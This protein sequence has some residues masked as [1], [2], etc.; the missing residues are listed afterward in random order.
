MG[1]FAVFFFFGVGVWILAVLSDA[2]VDIGLLYVA[3]FIALTFLMK[4]FCK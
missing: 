4:V 3:L 2:G 1:C